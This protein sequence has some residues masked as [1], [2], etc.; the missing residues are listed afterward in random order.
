MILAITLAI[1]LGNG[2]QQRIDRQARAFRIRL[3]P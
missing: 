1:T 2:R 3:P